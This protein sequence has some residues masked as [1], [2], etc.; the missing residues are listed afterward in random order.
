MYIYILHLLSLTLYTYT[1][2]NYVLCFPLQLSP[3]YCIPVLRGALRLKG[4]SERYMHQINQTSNVIY[5]YI[6][7][8]FTW[9]WM[10]S[11]DGVERPQR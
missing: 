11:L 9:L 7:P 3:V 1:L 8:I 5:I 10:H 6:Y 4:L 2:C